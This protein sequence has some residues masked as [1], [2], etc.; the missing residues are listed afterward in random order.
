MEK[1]ATAEEATVEVTYSPASAGLSSAEAARRLQTYG[2]NIFSKVEKISFLK[3]AI[4]EIKEP[5]MLLLLGVGILYSLWGDLGDAATIVIVIVLLLSVEIG[6]EFRAKKAIHSLAK[7]ASPV[8]RVVR[9]GKVRTIETETVVPGDHLV[10]TPGTLVTADGKVI[11][12]YGLQADES[13]L[14]GESMPLD[15]ADGDP[16]FAGTMII[17]GEGKAEALATGKETRIGQISSSA[18]T[19]E[20]PK[21]PLQKSMKSLAQ[22]LVVIAVFFSVTIPL[23]GFLR[24][25][26]PRQ[27]ILTALSL[28]FATV[29]EE[30]PL[31]ITIVLGVGAFTLSRKNLL[32]K[33]IK[34]AEVLGNATVIL[35]D[36]TGTITYNQMSVASIYPADGRKEVLEAAMGAQTETSTSP[37]DRAIREK[38]QQEG[39][40]PVGGVVIRQRGLGTGKKSRAVLREIDGTF[41]LFV[42]GAPEEIL[43]STRGTSGPGEWDAIAK[44]T[45]EG[46]RVIAVARRAVPAAD[47]SLPFPELERDLTLA[48]LIS[49]EDPPRKEAGDAIAQAMRAGVRTIMVTGDHPLTARQIAGAVGIPADRVV[50]G[51]ELDSMSDGQLRDAIKTVSVFART[52]P[53]HK[54]RLVRAL[55]ENGEVVA[56]TGDGVND[57]LALK[58]ADIGIAMG[59]RGTDAAKEA[60]DIIVAD[61]NYR[62]IGDGI[63]EGRKFFDNLSKGVKYYLSV[64]SALILIF[65]ISVLFNAPFPFS[66]INIIILELTLDLMATSTFVVEPAEKTIFTRPPRDPKKTLVDRPMMKRIAFSGISLFLAVMV[67]YSLALAAGV[68]LQTA[69]SIAFFAWLAGQVSLAYVARSDHEPLL[70]LGVFSNRMLNL[71][72]ILV[73]GITLAV[74]GLPGIAESI[75]LAP[76]TIVQLA[77]VIAFAFC[78]IFW[79]ELVKM[80]KFRKELVPK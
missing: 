52:T 33:K 37:T 53:E 15:K 26:E 66:P 3:I 59:V 10:L 34:A 45:G 65:L 42:S 50:T 48:G 76:I 63:F 73:A 60:A 78:L 80:W 23:L 35:T 72:L 31:I 9:D 28:V 36:K 32:V 29:P 22:K 57:A 67:P 38:C 39:V 27:M 69:R 12:S 16:V 71:M 68:E 7:L 14:T 54:Y 18:K 64:K 25:Q 4:K 47:Q 58:G 5:L 44:E 79:Q 6:N 30:L 24:G 61:D 1:E 46:R 11:R 21:T 55:H 17:G 41:E 49:I 43:R 75:K 2:R 74:L 62:T 40:Q 56:V 13:A 70:S 8:T 20:Q 77:G 51:E 19:I